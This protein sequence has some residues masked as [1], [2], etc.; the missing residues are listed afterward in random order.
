M[1]LSE[2][3]R[4]G[5][6]SST[7]VV[8]RYLYRMFKASGVDADRVFEQCGI[9]VSLLDDPHCRVLHEKLLQM[10]GVAGKLSADP[11]FGLN[12]ATGV[13]IAPF[14][15]A[16]YLAL[17]SANLREALSSLHRYNQLYT[18]AGNI[19]VTE[20]RDIT[21][22]VIDLTG[23]YEP[24]RHHTDFWMVFLY[25]MA[26]SFIGWELPLVE[27]GFRHPY[28]GD[29]SAYSD[30]FKCQLKFNQKENYFTFPSVYLDYQAIS[31]DS[32][33][34]K[35]HEMQAEQQLNA[36]SE[37]GII[38]KVKRAV[39][40]SLPAKDIELKD[41]SELLKLT[42]RTVQR[43]LSAEGATFKSIVDEARKE[44]TLAELR[45]NDI[46][47]SEVAFRLGYKDLSSFYRAYKRWT[48]TTPVSYRE[49]LQKP[50]S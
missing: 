5:Q 42:P 16:G 1:T 25:R 6:P 3:V 11:D 35:L 21:K 9:D 17:T 39:F 33:M 36:I 26:N 44:Y 37:T 13:P 38:N 45:I 43:H 14:N 10:W 12:L 50:D 22:V 47:V 8:T 7:A 4:G 48:G 30:V 15:A 18:D 46:S 27:A 34:H 41:V 2:S 32:G 23:K 24:V 31:A 29:Q 49:T 28:E 19:T 40:E 20:G